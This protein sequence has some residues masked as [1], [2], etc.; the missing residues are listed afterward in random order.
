MDWLALTL[1]VQMLRIHMRSGHASVRYGTTP[2]VA[3]MRASM[4]P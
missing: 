1:D 2:L 4:R 3:S